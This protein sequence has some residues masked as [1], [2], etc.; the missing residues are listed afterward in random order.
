MKRILLIEDDPDI[1][2]SIKYNLE[3]EEGFAVATARD[4]SA[5]L[6]KALQH[7]PD[8][9]LLDLSLP[10]MTGLDICRRLRSEK[11][12][13][14]L[15]II[16][17]TA[18]VE[19]SDKIAGLELGADDYITKPFSVREVIARVRA[20][21]RRSEQVEADE[22]EGSL[23]HGPLEVDLASRRATVGG[24]EISL[25]RKEFDL[26]VALLRSRGRV[27]TRSYL[28]E[29]I[30]GYDYPGETRTVDVHIRK[31]RKKLGEE[32]QDVIETVVGVGYRFTDP[33]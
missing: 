1:A 30:W 24:Q 4:G 16:M 31:L 13:S 8:L 22:G 9:L 32:A 15:P 23:T 28:L 17:L 11:R 20:V 5:G 27:L 7:P 26:L 3:K 33:S 14:R 19:E 6:Q 29:H 25:A 21:L 2:L 12:T 10:G 18:R